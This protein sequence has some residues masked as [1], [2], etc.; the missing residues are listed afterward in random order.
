MRKFL[1]YALLLSAA[2]ATGCQ[3]EADIRPSSYDE[4][5]LDTGHWE[6]DVSTLGWAGNRTPATEGYTRQLVFGAGGQLL[7]RRSG[8]GDVRTS[9][10]L[11]MGQLPRCGTN[12][13]NFP[14]VTYSTGEEKL[15]N[16]ERKTYT[17]S[18][19]NGLQV[20]HITGEDACFD[21]G[22]YETYH[23]VAD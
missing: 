21:G 2:L 9:Y 11:S 10:Q 1:R 8:Q 7:L 16:N 12:Q 20:L 19:Q 22:A 13:A 17:I 3:R 14:I 15:P 18:Q 23:W 5:A 4:L 6:W